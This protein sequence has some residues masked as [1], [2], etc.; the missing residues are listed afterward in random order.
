MPVLVHAAH[1]PVARSL[2]LRLVVEGG[3]VRAT[4]RDGVAALRAQG[5][6]TAACDP[7]DEGRL[8]AALTQVHTLVV[9][10]GGLGA[11]DVDAI[12]REGEA[13][14]RAADGAGVARVILVTIAGAD[15][16]AADPL[17]RAHGAVAQAFAALPLPTVE[18][19]TGLLATPATDDLL[20]G[21]GLPQEERQREVA[22]VTVDDLIELLVSIDHARSRAAGGHLVVAA[23]G[24][25]RR[26]L[27]EQL[28][29]ASGGPTAR[30]LGRRVP[31]PAART[32]LI[33]ALE[34]PWWTDD[35]LVP[36]A[37]ALFDVPVARP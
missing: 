7:D 13:A 24:P 22:P 25:V 5:V 35:P 6:F 26:T 10:L 19:R 21:A 15:P 23:D 18:V 1:R 17:R 8:E 32:A 34:G 37:W 12:R 33:A 3:Q 4:A 11:P 28:A 20:L 31:G 30:R 14:A 27:D 36:D 9:L 29:L 2:A 16:A